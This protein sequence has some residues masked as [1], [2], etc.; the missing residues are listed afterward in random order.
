MELSYW[1]SRW[2]KNNTGWHM[3]TVYP[4]LPKLWPYLSIDKNSEVLVPLCGKSRDIRWLLEEGHTVTG[5]EISSKAIQKIKENY[6]HTFSKE[7]SH[8]FIVHSSDQLTLWEGDFLTLPPDQVPAPAAIYDKAAIVALPP[9]MREKY[10]QKI[11]ALCDPQTQILLQTFE[12]EQDEMTGP[13]FS[14]PESE[15]H[16]RFGSHFSL[17]LLHEQSKFDQLKKFQQRG[18]SSGLMEKVFLLTPS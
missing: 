2:Q 17:H 1:Q 9:A 16:K 13:P 3:E 7:R 15:I 4:Q 10:A 11:M 8:G 5:V 6:P 18:L 12:Y 14:V